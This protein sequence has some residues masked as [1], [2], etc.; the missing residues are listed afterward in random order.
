M[1]KPELKASQNQN[2]TSQALS[3]SGANEAK[4]TVSASPNSEGVLKTVF[5]FKR[6]S[7]VLIGGVGGM[8]MAR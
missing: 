2:D 3:K 8:V 4:W 5:E 6:P 7:F 1:E